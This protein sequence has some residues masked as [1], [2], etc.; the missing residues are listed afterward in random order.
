VLRHA[1]RGWL[2]CVMYWRCVFLVGL[3][4]LHANHFAHRNLSFESCVVGQD[5][6]VRLMGFGLTPIFPGSHGPLGSVMFKP[7]EASSVSKVPL[8]LPP[9]YQLLP[10]MDSVPKIE[11]TRCPS[12]PH[13]CATAFH[14]G[15]VRYALC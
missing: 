15:C 10:Y 3:D 4:C 13:P 9:L 7:P 12:I 6:V 8:Q 11:H 2:L 14:T 1:V 5:G